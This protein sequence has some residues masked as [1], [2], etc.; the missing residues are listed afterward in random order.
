MAGFS[1]SSQG[2][3]PLQ[4][5][6]SSGGTSLQPYSSNNASTPYSSALS[7]A[8]APNMSTPQGPRYA[9]PPVVTPLSF[10]A[11]STPVKKQ[12]V[13]NTDGSTHTTEYHAPVQPATPGLLTSSAQS[14]TYAEGGH[15]IIP[16]LPQTEQTS[17]PSQSTSAGA[18]ATQS[19][20]Q[21]QQ[22]PPTFQGLLSTLTNSALQG[23]PTAQG[24]IGQTSSAA[25]GAYG[26]G[27]SQ[28]ADAYGKAQDFQSQY[29]QNQQQEADALAQ[30][31]LNPIPIGD[32]AGREAVLQNQYLA[33]QNALASGLQGESN[34]ANIGLSGQGQGLSG[35]GTASGQAVTGQGQTLSGLTSA[36]GA[37]QPQLAGFN[38][39]VFN[40][41]TGQF[42]GGTSLNDAV[43]TITQ[44]VQSGQMSYDQA[45]TSLGGYGQG[46]INA[47]QQALGP[48]FNVAQ[49]N[50]LAG[51][52]GAVGPAVQYANSAL[53]LLTDAA[54]K[55]S[56]FGQGSNVPIFN[57][58]GT[59]VSS[60]TGL[61]GDQTQ[62]YKSAVA[63]A[64]AALTNV[65]IQKGVTPTAA[66]DQANAL[67]P[68]N[69][70]PQQISAAK[71]TL[72]TFGQSTQSIYGN[73]GA[74]NTN[75]NSNAQSSTNP[76]GWF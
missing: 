31:R 38:Q 59:A 18:T 25:Q 14:P 35:L 40:P 73:P 71:Q 72:A 7:K 62:A 49:S 46:G 48:N 33:R 42:A 1:F 41:L 22:T 24:L 57:A 74:V 44:R 29:V 61:G 9:A 19:Q 4:P 63:E 51:V 6:N 16:T 21:T 36:L 55:L 3:T 28:L 67:I 66:G 2:S 56:V 8:Q 53:D 27:A 68:D 52:Q 43:S 32:Q 60:A 45:V 54:S 47:L 11:P 5:Y 15:A 30:N 23:S 20:L 65:F 58:A 26:T 75:S 34:L 10:A 12:V 17:A 50:A 70:T 37:A 64:R 69:P 13:T 39:Q 76:P